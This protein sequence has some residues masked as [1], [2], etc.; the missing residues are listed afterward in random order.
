MF[1]RKALWALAAILSTTTLAS[2]N[3]GK[4]PEPTPDVNALYT[5]AAGTLIA[6]MSEQ[7]TETALAASPTAASSPTPLASRTPLPTFPSIGVLTPFGTFAAGLTPLATSP[8]TVVVSNPVGCNDA[9]YIGGEPR[10]GKIMNPQHGFDA[11]WSLLNRGTCTW[12]EG[13]EFAFKSGDRL[14]GSNVKIR[15]ESQ[16]TEPGHSQAFVIPMEAPKLAGEY[17]GFWQMRSDDGTW[18]GS[19]VW[20]NI[21][22]Q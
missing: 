16:F 20:V 22:V 19:L 2:C 9:Q 5:A 14:S 3:L 10:D 11:S 8:G 4:S 13:Y 15:L 17:K 21:V 1:H 6:Q 18:F 12:D 7:Q